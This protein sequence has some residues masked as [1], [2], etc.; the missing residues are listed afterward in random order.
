[1]VKVEIKILIIFK[2][3]EKIHYILENKILTKY[4]TSRYTHT[5][6]YHHV[7]VDEAQDLPGRWLELLDGIVRKTGQSHI[8]I[9][10]DPVQVVRRNAERPEI[11]R[12]QMHSLKKV[13]RNTHNVFEAYEY[14]HESLREEAASM[15]R[16]LSDKE[17]SPPT[18]E[19]N[20]YG[21]TPEYITEGSG[22]QLKHELVAT[23][24]RLQ[25]QGVVF[26]DIAIIT[27]GNEVQNVTDHLKTAG[28][29]CENAEKAVELKYSNK[30]RKSDIPV[31]V[32][33]YQRFKGLE[34][35]VLI[36]FIPPSWKPDDVDI[37]VGFSR[38]FC[39]LIVIGTHKTIN[40]IKE[41]QEDAMRKN[42]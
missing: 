22:E 27:C 17:L 2:E 4:A 34:S 42:A 12:F 3:D 5:P 30:R 29:R 24:E 6:K 10:E 23:L 19:H 38:S 32:D 7:L 16:S 13:I 18:I 36:Y 9:F 8:S 1:L 11:A 26:L 14:S 40:N 28:I 21:Q 39:H 15:E 37:Y 35:K 25:S 41:R 33:S 31:I 20:V